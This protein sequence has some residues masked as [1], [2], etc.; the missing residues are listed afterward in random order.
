MLQ[1]CHW[2]AEITPAN[3]ELVLP[4]TA[5]EWRCLFDNHLHVTGKAKEAISPAGL[6]LGGTRGEPVDEHIAE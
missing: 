6:Q 2:N 4:N 3:H 5:A 1:H